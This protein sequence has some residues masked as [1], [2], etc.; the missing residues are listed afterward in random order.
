WLQTLIDA[1]VDPTDFDLAEAYYRLGAG[2]GGAVRR[3]DRPF[4]ALYE[5]GEIPLAP[6]ERVQE[7][8]QRLRAR[9]VV[10]LVEGLKPLMAARR[11]QESRLNQLLRRPVALDDLNAAAGL[12]SFTP[13]D[14][15]SPAAR[16]AIAAC[17]ARDRAETLARGEAL[18]AAKMTIDGA[19]ETLNGERRARAR[20]FIAALK[21]R[22]DAL[23]AAG[24]PLTVPP[25]DGDVAAALASP[26]STSSDPAAS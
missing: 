12:P 10:A 21:T 9:T 6:V 1:P 11:E 26:P 13:I 17:V 18:L 7:W 4:F 25:S 19:L 5:S 20:R 16:Q 8:R 3:L 14:Q 2:V 24:E 22:L 23:R 15:W